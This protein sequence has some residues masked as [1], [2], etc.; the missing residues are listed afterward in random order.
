MC[1][2]IDNNYEGDAV[3]ET[4]S[5]LSMGLIIKSQNLRRSKDFLSSLAYSCGLLGISDDYLTKKEDTGPAKDNGATFIGRDEMIY[6]EQREVIEH[7][8]YLSGKI[9]EFSNI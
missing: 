9:L 6:Q 7:L 5:P 2:K 8:E 4:E 3:R 1:E